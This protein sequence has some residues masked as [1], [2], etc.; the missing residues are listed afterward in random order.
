MSNSPLIILAAGG[1][2]GHIFP[3]EALARELIARNYQVRLVTDPRGGKFGDDLKD[4][5]VTRIRAASLGGSLL[6]KT[7]GALEMAMGTLQ[8]FFLLRRLK[9]ALVVGFGGYPSV[10][11]VFAASRLNIPVMLHEQNAVL[12]RANKVMAPLARLIATSFPHVSRLEGAAAA[13]ASLTGNPVRPAIC[14]LHDKP[15]P[16]SSEANPLRLLVMGGSL[17]AQVFADVVPKAVALLPEVL[18]KRLMISQQCRK[19]DMAPARMAYDALG[20]RVEMAPFFHD[21]PE[22][23]AQC[24][25]AICRSG[26]ST[27]AELC[28]AGRPAV[29]V[30]YPY[31]IADEQKANAQTMAEAG[32]G[33]LI[34]QAAFTPEALAVRLESL[35]VIPGALAKAAEAAKGLARL[36][37]AGRLADL[38]VSLID[39]SADHGD[40]GDSPENS[41]RKAA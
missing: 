26:A 36:N 33:W 37:A 2:G 41:N 12:G 16:F 40:N 23:L 24:H 8:A 13:K 35:I 9:P 11:T 6:S 29:L 39:L 22:R 20:L 31:A 10:P 27:V 3:S 38:A 30:P 28:M 18:R 32:A 15:Y 19:E 17:G 4:V 14:A 21:I 7:R 34:P 5:A 1:T 25:L